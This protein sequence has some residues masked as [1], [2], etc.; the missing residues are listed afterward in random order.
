MTEPDE[1]D[2]HVEERGAGPIV[3]LAHGFGGSARNFRREARALQDR[4]RV[5]LWDARGHARSAAP[6][7]PAL[8]TAEQMVADVGRVLGLIRED[9]TAQ[10]APSSGVSP[11]WGVRPSSSVP[12]VVVGGLSM[13]AGIALGY[14][15][16]HPERVRALVL[17]AFPPGAREP[18]EGGL[19]QAEWASSF[20]D[21]IESKGL[22][23]GA[24]E[25]A[26]GPRSGF[27][28]ASAKRVRQGFLEH[29]PHGMEHVLRG[30]LATQRSAAELAPQ[31]RALRVPALVVAGAEDRL[32]RGP[33]EVLA[34]ALPG[35]RLVVIPGAG[36]VVNLDATAAFDRALREFLDGLPAA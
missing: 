34:R 18:R 15:L 9:G 20:A 21:A 5:V 1:V 28:A 27:D 23:A 12:R 4:H 2:L 22:E 8:Y 7:D 17:A 25:Y 3:A 24:A 36:H 16:A 13:G 32:S 26:W 33:S 14:A 30:V 29:T 31:L 10:A 6:T 19:T 11:A 35:A